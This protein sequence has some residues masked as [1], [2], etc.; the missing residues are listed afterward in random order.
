MDDPLHPKPIR[1]LPAA[2]AFVLLFLCLSGFAAPNGPELK[3]LAVGDWGRDGLFD[4]QAVADQMNR[5]ASDV[6][7][8]FVVSL[9]DNFYPDGVASTESAQWRTSFEGVYTGPALQVPWYVV[10]GNHDYHLNAQ[11]QVDYTLVSPRWKMPARWYR[12]VRRIDVDTTVEFFFLDTNPYL[13]GYRN[14]PEKYQGIGD[15][16][17]ERQTAWLET[18]LSRSTAAWK[19][20]CAH[21][22][23]FSA[24]ATHGDTPELSTAILPLLR[25]YGVQVYLNG[26]EHDLQHLRVHGIDFFCSGAGSQTRATRRDD[27][28]QYSLGETPGFL[29]VSLGRDQA[30][31]RFIDASGTVRYST[32]VV[33]PPVPAESATPAVKSS[34]P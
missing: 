28:T 21:H 1:L 25:R 31:F 33:R 23:I 3:F 4:Q 12:V 7:A 14:N 19:I 2:L 22:P 27:R 29:A 18:A 8:Q 16:S 32:T 11:A 5:T 9:G 15:E 6:S 26:H 10:L 34:A 30:H 20:V 17:P 13:T 24:S